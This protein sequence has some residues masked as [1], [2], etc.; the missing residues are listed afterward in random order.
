MIV[1][2]DANIVIY[3]VENDPVWGQKAK[4]RIT[5]AH[6]AG[7]TLATSDASRLECL[8]GPVHSG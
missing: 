4:V 6:A 2:L 7:D 5:A 1:Y 3:L 8:G